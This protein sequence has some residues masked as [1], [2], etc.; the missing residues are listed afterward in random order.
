MPKLPPCS[1]E[2][3]FPTLD[4]TLWLIKTI[5]NLVAFKFILVCL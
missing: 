1:D 2:S 4:S 5:Y 3:T